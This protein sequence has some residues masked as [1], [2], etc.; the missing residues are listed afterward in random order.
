MGVLLGIAIVVVAIIVGSR[1]LPKPEKKIEW[2]RQADAVIVQMK[3][4][5]GL[6]QPGLMARPTVPDFTLYGD[7]TVIFTQPSKRGQFAPPLLLQAQLPADSMRDLLTFIDATGFFSFTYDQPRL[8]FYDFATTYLYASTKGQANAVSAYALDSARP[9]RPEWDQFR[10]LREIK[11]RLD[12]TANNTVAAGAAIT[13]TTDAI[14][15]S[16]QYDGPASPIVS[17]AAR[18]P[19]EWPFADIDLAS[20]AAATGFGERHIKGDQAQAILNS[21]T[22]I[23]GGFFIQAGRDF[24]VFYRPVLPYEENFPEFEPPAGAPTPSGKLSS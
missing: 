23:N 8:G 21:A 5:G 15:L 1:W 20:I 10:K 6:P 12:A 9:A 22:P 18:R 13:Y 7:G 11:S 2:V 4:V 19:L 17:A 16:V 24:W 3:T 14:V